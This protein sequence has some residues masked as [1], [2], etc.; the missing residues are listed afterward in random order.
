M[1]NIATE[2]TATEKAVEEK[3]I[4]FNWSM[5]TE[6]DVDMVFDILLPGFDK[7]DF[8]PKGLMKRVSKKARGRSPEEIVQSYKDKIAKKKQD[9]PEEYLALEIAEVQDLLERLGSTINIAERYTE[10]D[11][12]KAYRLLAGKAK[13]QGLTIDAIRQMERKT[14]GR[15]GRF[16]LIV[17]PLTNTT[18]P[19]GYPEV[20]STFLQRLAEAD[21]KAEIGRSQ[22]ARPMAVAK[23]PG[24][25][26]HN[27]LYISLGKE[28]KLPKEMLNKPD[29]AE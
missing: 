4:E 5:A 9:I 11:Q 29:S 1:D 8:S 20:V 25:L 22:S 21:P 27:V 7:E 3:K 19:A 16:S 18:A 2:T 15:R 10:T 13:K 24:L 23:L 17:T 28:F 12:W 14:A 26:G 6:A